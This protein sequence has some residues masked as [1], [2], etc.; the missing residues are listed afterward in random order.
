MAENPKLNISYKMEFPYSI[1][2]TSVYEVWY[3]ILFGHD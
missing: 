2:T 3:S 1:H